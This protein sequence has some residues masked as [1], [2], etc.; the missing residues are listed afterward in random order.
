MKHN[1]IVG[2]VIL[3][4]GQSAMAAFFQQNSKAEAAKKD[5]LLK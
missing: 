2:I 5:R 4:L 3:G 1:W